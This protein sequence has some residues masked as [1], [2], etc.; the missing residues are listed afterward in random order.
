MTTFKCPT[1]GGHWQE[2]PTRDMREDTTCRKCLNAELAAA[3]GHLQAKIAEAVRLEDRLRASDGEAE[4]RNAL[5]V[6]DEE[7]IRDLVDTLRIYH[8]A[9]TTDN[10]VPSFAAT[11]ALFLLAKHPISQEPPCQP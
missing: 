3:Y 9:W 10:R 6:Q 8:H 1:C 11:K 4:R 7:A 5:A 2:G